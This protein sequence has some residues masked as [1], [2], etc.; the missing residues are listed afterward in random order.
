LFVPIPMLRNILFVEPFHSRSNPNTPV[1]NYTFIGAIFI[2]V[3]N[4]T[5]FTY[6]IT[7]AHAILAPRYYIRKVATYTTMFFDFIGHE[8][9]PCLL[10]IHVWSDLV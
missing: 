4:A 9:S 2:T 5:T 7:G 10:R 3:L 1:S 8:N 6:L